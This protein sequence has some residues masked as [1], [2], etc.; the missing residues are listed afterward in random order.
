M[1]KKKLVNKFKRKVFG[2]KP[3]HLSSQ[4]EMDASSEELGQHEQQPSMRFKTTLRKTSVST[5]AEN[6]HAS[7]LHEG[8]LRYKYN[9][10]NDTYDVYDDT[11]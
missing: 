6:D 4:Y 10:S 2:S 9:P 1:R 8:N 11:D 3:K 5:N 7:S